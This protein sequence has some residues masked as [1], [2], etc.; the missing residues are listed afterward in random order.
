[1]YEIELLSAWDLRRPGK[2]DEAY[3]M[4]RNLLADPSLGKWHQADFHLLLG[5][6]DNCKYVCILTLLTRFKV[7]SNMRT[8]GHDNTRAETIVSKE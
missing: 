1:M 2:D 7:M 3:I 6:S 5:Y 4:C 8:D